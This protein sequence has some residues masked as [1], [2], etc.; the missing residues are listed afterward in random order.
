M[1][2]NERLALTNFPHD[3][4]NPTFET[5]L[6]W[7]K[8]VSTLPGEAIKKSI[9]LAANGIGVDCDE[10]PGPPTIF[11]VKTEGKEVIRFCVNERDNRPIVTYEIAPGVEDE[12]EPIFDRLGQLLFIEAGKLESP[13][14]VG[15]NGAGPEKPPVTTPPGRPKL[16]DNDKVE[17]DY[18]EQKARE[19]IA[20]KKS[21]K[22][23]SWKEIAYE[24]GWSHGTNEAGIKK[25]KRAIGDW[26]KKT[27]TT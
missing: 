20:I 16:A 13:Q 11:V 6:A 26:T 27:E 17:S 7:Q 23:L 4:D 1:D 18:R 2:I 8:L 21:D 3:D 24:I 9:R 5:W 14:S 15:G 22:K 25:L 19:A 12:I 10:K